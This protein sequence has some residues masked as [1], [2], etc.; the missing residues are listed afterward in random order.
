MPM[1][2]TVRDAARVSAVLEGQSVAASVEGVGR[3][4]L[5]GR[6]GDLEVS[7]SDAARFSAEGIQASWVRIRAQDVARVYVS[8]TADRADVTVRPRAGIS[9]EALQVKSIKTNTE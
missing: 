1:K 4:D 7:A 9:L 6:I 3:A 2:M 8:G 5:S